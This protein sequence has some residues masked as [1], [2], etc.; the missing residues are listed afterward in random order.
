MENPC[1]CVCVCV[2][3]LCCVVCVREWSFLFL[4]RP[5]REMKKRPGERVVVLQDAR[6]YMR[7]FLHGHLHED[8]SVSRSVAS[9]LS[10]FH[11]DL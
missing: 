6:E 2:C 7:I 8:I 3:V 5:P 10:S 9:I 1:V 4:L 11:D